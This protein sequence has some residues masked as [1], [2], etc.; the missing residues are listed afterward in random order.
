LTRFPVRVQFLFV[1]LV[2]AESQPVEICDEG[3]RLS[4]RAQL[5][6]PDHD[7]YAATAA[8]YRAGIR[9]GGQIVV[10]YPSLVRL[11]GKPDVPSLCL[12]GRS[13][14]VLVLASCHDHAK[15]GGPK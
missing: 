12:A 6:L 4:A 9:H 5:L 13:S 8:I 3:T 11:T 14:P 7:D 1:L 2:G 15:G 10:K